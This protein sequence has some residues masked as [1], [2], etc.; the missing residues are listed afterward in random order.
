MGT[1]VT[2]ETWRSLILDAAVVYVNYGEPDQSVLGATNGGVTFGWEEFEVRSPE[3]DGIKGRL[4][5]ASRIT[6]ASPQVV[7]S[8]VEWKL[9]AIQLAFPGSDVVIAG[10]VATLTRS[11]RTIPIE[12]YPKNIAMVGTQSGTGNPVVAMIMRPMVVDGAEIPT[13]DES[14][15]TADL[16]FV[17]HYDPLNPELEPWEIR[18]PLAPSGLTLNQLVVNPAS[19]SGDAEQ[20]D[21][22]GVINGRSVGSTIVSTDDRVQ[23]VGG[24]LQV[25]PGAPLDPSSTFEVILVETLA[26]ASNSPRATPITITVTEA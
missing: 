6:R 23:I 13:E 17:G 2:A 19:V 5:G 10:G 3:I 7:V 14:E 25:G 4:A 24:D 22:I 9:S 21:V 12:E 20:G 1:G 11:G 8:L 16:T 18:W 26:T 15:S